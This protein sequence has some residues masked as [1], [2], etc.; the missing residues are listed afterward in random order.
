MEEL[1]GD[2][3]AFDATA[4]YEA[5]IG[6]DYMYV[7]VLNMPPYT[8]TAFW[9]EADLMAASADALEDLLSELEAAFG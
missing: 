5:E 7:S 2:I 4:A 1:I 8:L 3:E 9:D 6:R